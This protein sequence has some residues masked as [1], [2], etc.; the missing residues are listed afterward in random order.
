MDVLIPA[1]LE[2]AITAE[3]VDLAWDHACPAT[4]QMASAREFRDA[5]QIPVTAHYA[6]TRML[7]FSTNNT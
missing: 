6:A 5:T 7:N 4:L 2:D 3:N 1:V